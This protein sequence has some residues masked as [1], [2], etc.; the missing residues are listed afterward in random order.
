MDSHNITNTSP[1]KSLQILMYYKYSAFNKKK[2]HTNVLIN[3]ALITLAMFL[4]TIS[5]GAG[6]AVLAVVLEVLVFVF[7]LRKI[8]L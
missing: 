1:F 8:K 2:A 6:N 4:I 7:L 5:K 3:M